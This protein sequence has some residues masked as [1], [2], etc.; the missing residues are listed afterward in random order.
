M[1]I[2]MNDE[3]KMIK[4]VKL[5]DFGFAVYKD[6]VNDLPPREKFAGTPGFIAPEIY[7]Q[8]A[9]DEKI[10][11]FSLGIILY[12]MLSGKL[13]FQSDFLEEI[14]DMTKNCNYSL[15]NI[16]WS[17]VSDNA[18]DL[19]R[20]TLTFKDKRISASDIAKHPWLENTEELKQYMGR[21]KRPK[22][23]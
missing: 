8:V 1:Q 16:H 6:K 10:D 13:P 22:I 15:L 9:Y 12:F 5:I 20:S 11:I 17:N 7:Q 3:K 14:E 2:V 21:N 4:R 18:K 23:L 19:I